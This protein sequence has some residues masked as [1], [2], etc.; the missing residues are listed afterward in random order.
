MNSSY[1]KTCQFKAD[2]EN[3]ARGSQ[4][5]NGLRIEAISFLHRLADLKALFGQHIYMV[6]LLSKPQAQVSIHDILTFMFN[7]VLNNMYLPRWKPLFGETVNNCEAPHEET[8]LEA[9]L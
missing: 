9:T 4:N 5:S 1:A 2:L 7:V 8:V 6:K 3:N